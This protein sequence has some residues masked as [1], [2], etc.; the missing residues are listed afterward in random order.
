MAQVIECL[1]QK[2]E[3]LSST[4]GTIKKKKKK[5]GELELIVLLVQCLLMSQDPPVAEPRPVCTQR[6]E[7]SMEGTSYFLAP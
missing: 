6:Q 2:C 7:V 4:C 5:Q 1:P 3:V